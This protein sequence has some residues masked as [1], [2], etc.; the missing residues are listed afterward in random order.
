MIYRIKWTENLWKAIF[1]FVKEV[2]DA[3]VAKNYNSEFD[4]NVVD[5]E[6]NWGYDTMTYQEKEDIWNISTNP[7]SGF[8]GIGETVK[9]SKLT[10]S[11]KTSDNARTVREPTYYHS[12]HS[13][14]HFN[15]DELVESNR[16]T[17]QDHW[18]TLSMNVTSTSDVAVRPDSFPEE[19]WRLVDPKE[20]PLVESRVQKFV[21][22]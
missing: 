14:R 7:K 1:N 10:T 9:S 15:T 20:R 16:A 8:L 12:S 21:S 22:Q 11:R 19:L 17:G 18:D 5:D 3:S 2:T 6:T 4:E 13:R